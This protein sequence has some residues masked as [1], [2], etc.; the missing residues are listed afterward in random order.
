MIPAD[1]IPEPV[2]V[3]RHVIEH[4]MVQSANAYGFDVKWL[5]LLHRMEGGK[6][7]TVKLNKDGSYDL[8]IMQINTINLADLKRVKPD[9]TWKN[10]AV[11]PCRNIDASAWYFTKMLKKRKGNLW[12][13]IGDYNS[14]TP[15]VRH[16]YLVRAMSIYAKYSHKW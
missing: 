8:G 6:S 11:E 2:D 16:T 5:K 3:P 14:T 7:G 12:E 9:T 1:Q 4:C 15:K 13:A 10:L